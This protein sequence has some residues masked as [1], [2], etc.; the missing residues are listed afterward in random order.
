MLSVNLFTTSSRLLKN[1]S[2][3]RSCYNRRITL[4]GSIANA[5]FTTRKPFNVAAVTLALKIGGG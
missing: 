5:C 1:D 3:Y 4:T 2:R